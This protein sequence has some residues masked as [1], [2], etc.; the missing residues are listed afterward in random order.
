MSKKLSTIALVLV[1]LIGL[2]L[3]LYPTVSDYWNSRRQ[4]RA[5]ASYLEAV[6][7]LDEEKYA[8][9][10]SDAEAFNAMLAKEK[11]GLFLTDEQKE[12]YYKL[13]DVS[14]SGI[15][16]Y[17]DIDSIDC[18]LPVYHGTSGDVLQIA[19]GHLEGASLPI[20]GNSTH[21]VLS[22]HRGLP[23]A[24]LFSDL[25]KLAVGD[26]FTV[27]ILD[28]VLTYEIYE[29]STVL[30]HEADSLKIEEGR[31]L[32]TLVTCTPYGVNTHRLLLRAHRVET[33]EEVKKVRVVADALQ[34]EPIIVAPILAIPMLI[35]LF[36]GLIFQP[37]KKK[38]GE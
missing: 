2:S 31:D 7:N 26:T 34:I 25:D 15:M 20:G 17:I 32:C 10:F 18:H 33:V 22:G 24:K 9:L 5:I 36:I 14:G 37:N 21:S 4:S 29:I 30:P 13:L 11:K 6:K 35:A 23:S 1:F 27:N 16:G 8:K 12:E 3:L 19:V 28:E 38:K